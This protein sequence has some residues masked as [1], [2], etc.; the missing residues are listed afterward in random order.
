MSL[1]TLLRTTSTSGKLDFGGIHWKAY[2]MAGI[3]SSTSW[4]LSSIC[5]VR[6]ARPI[7]LSNL[8]MSSVSFFQLTSF[9]TGQNA[10]PLF[11]RERSASVSSEEVRSWDSNPA[12]RLTSVVTP[13]S[14]P[15]FLVGALIFLWAVLS[16]RRIISYKLE[17]F[18]KRPKQF[19][20]GDHFS[21]P[22][23]FD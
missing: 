23:R 20:L 19:F 4:G 12:G 21:Q 18:M 1:F 6:T 2:G 11:R 10:V 9:G 15:S 7:L 5:C 13:C 17:Q 22:I 3:R 8:S 16:R 14:L